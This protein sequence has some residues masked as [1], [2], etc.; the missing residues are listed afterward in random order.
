M[1]C[2]RSYVNR[3][4]LAQ[5]PRCRRKDQSKVK[6]CSRF[7]QFGSDVVFGKWEALWG[8]AVVGLWSY[9]FEAAT[10][11]DSLPWIGLDL[12]ASSGYTHAAY[13]RQP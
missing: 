3:D 11:E 12:S 9:C 13:L 7:D 6:G 2:L 5:R 8:S 4:D 10:D 1:A